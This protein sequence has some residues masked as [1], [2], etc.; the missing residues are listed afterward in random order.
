MRLSTH[1]L[2]RAFATGVIVCSTDAGYSQDYPNKPIRFIVPHAAGGSSDILARVI[3]PRLA[4][5]LGQPVVVDNRGGAGAIIGT[6]L[7]AKA[8]ADGYT[9]MLAD[10]PHGA[11]PALHG[12]LPYDTLRDF[13]PITLVSLMPSI[14]IVHPSVAATSVRELIA[15]AKARPGQLNYASGGLASS[16]Y[17]TM[18]LFVDRTG[19]NVFHVSYKSGAPALVDLIG[20]QVQMQFVNVPPALQHVRADRVRALGVTSLKRVQSLPDVPTIAESG[21]AGFED[22]Q[23]QG[24]VAPAGVPRTTVVKLNTAITK[25]LAEPEVRERLLGMSI[26]VIGSSP[27]HL[28]DFI[29]FQVDRWSKV[30]KPGTIGHSR[31][32]GQSG[33]F[34]RP[35]RRRYLLPAWCRC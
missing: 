9:V 32:R 1:V 16:I 3:V 35:A 22:Y 21:V 4:E 11:N 12:K 31:P 5:S 19:I 13:V 14:L 25:V 26:V 28:G 20:G 17:L 30:I 7:A 15:L 34:T 27:E 18:A 29:Q 10:V 2:L 33:S 6:T 8:P 24:V 23:W